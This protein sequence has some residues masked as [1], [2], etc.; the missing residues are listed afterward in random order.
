MSGG[1]ASGRKG[2]RYEQ[3]LVRF[4]HDAGYGALR[5]PS[6]GSATDRDLPDVL[7]GYPVVYPY[8]KHDRIEVEDRSHVQS[9]RFATDTLA[10][11]LKS[12]KATTL[13]VDE[14]EVEDLRAFAER[15]GATTYL[16]AR[17]TTQAT[18]REHYLVRPDDARRTDGGRYGLPRADLA[19][20]ASLV[21]GPDGVEH[22]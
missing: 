2:T 15:W 22:L 3:Q 20:R 16:G 4:L 7:A 9:D 14:S 11:E 13:Y 12:G 5:L 1:A 17:P 18:G 6:S 21:V 10:V 19:E 8:G